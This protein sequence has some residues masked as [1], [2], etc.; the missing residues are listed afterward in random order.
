MR[1]AGQLRLLVQTISGYTSSHL[2]LHC[3]INDQ[4]A[5]GIHNTMG[6]EGETNERMVPCV[7]CLLIL[8]EI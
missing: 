3:I 1:V 6:L 2:R 8:L 7:L 4:L 5:N